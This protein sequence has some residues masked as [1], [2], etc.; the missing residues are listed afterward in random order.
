MA[1]A[2]DTTSNSATASWSH[3]C[4]GANLILIV[5]VRANASGASTSCTYNG[6]GMTQLSARPYNSSNAHLVTFYLLNPAT[7]ANTITATTGSPDYGCAVSY[8]GVA[9]I[10]SSGNSA[11]NQNNDTAS[12]S[13]TTVADNSRAIMTVGQGGGA[14]QTAGASTTK[15]IASATSDINAI[16]D[17]NANKT[18]AGAVTLIS[19]FTSGVNAW[20]TF[21]IKPSITYTENISD[22]IA[23]TESVSWGNKIS[24][25]IT[26][27]TVNFENVSDSI[28]MTDTIQTFNRLWKNL[29]KSVTTWTNQDKS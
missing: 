12:G 23:L 10:D 26:M 3:T 6:V 7:G 4:T 2:V 24:E 11:S 20:Q 22:S 19:T 18:P 21:S 25:L 13:V 5:A 29:V 17:P 8:T 27:V 1:I 15:R 9:G 14:T 16:F 28:G